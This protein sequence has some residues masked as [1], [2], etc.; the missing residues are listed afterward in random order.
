VKRSSQNAGI[1]REGKIAKRIMLV[2]LTNFFFGLFPIIAGQLSILDYVN[3][4]LDKK[5]YW[6]IL[7][8]YF[9]VINPC[10]N[11]VL[12]AFRNEKFQS[13]IKRLLKIRQ[14]VVGIAHNNRTRPTEPEQQNKT[15]RKRPTEQDQQ[16]QN[17][18]RTTEQEQQ[19]KDNRTRTTEQGQQN[20]NNR[21]RTTEQGQQNKDNRTRTTEQG[22]QN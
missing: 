16:N 6:H 5:G 4:G 20:K 1:K 14:N 21:T 18:T 2:I 7:V 15:N 3:I 9:F 12:F 22:Q 17:R 11:P 8:F 13:R 10:L 19:N